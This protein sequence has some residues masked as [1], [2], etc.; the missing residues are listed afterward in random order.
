[1]DHLR[2]DGRGWRRGRPWGFLALIPLGLFFAFGLGGLGLPRL[3]AQALSSAPTALPTLAPPGTALLISGPDKILGLPFF[4][5][6]SIP[7]IRGKYLIGADWLRVWFTREPLVFGAAWIA[8]DSWAGISGFK[9]L[10]MGT[11]GGAL[12]LAMRN[13]GWTLILELP[14]ADPAIRRFVSA[15][16]KRFTFFLENS[17]SDADLSFPATVAY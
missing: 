12:D 17:G 7:T 1:M 16:M 2:V 5:P 9:A 11:A 8:D 14:S 13:A 4:S 3:A 15:F 6:N 10:T